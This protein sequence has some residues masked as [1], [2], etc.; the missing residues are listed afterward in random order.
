[1]HIDPWH[2]L[3]HV[4]AARIALGRS[5]GSVPTREQLDFRLAHA[6]ARDAVH[7][8][9]DPDALREKLEAQGTPAMIV[10]SAARDRAE[11]LQRPD[12][13]RIL[14][15]ESR[16]LLVKEAAAQTAPCDLAIIV[17]DGLST[18]AA[19]TQSEPLLAALLPQVRALGWTLAPIVVASHGRVALQDEVGHLFRA[20][21]S[22]MLIGERP[23]LGNADSLGAYFTF[24]PAP[25]KTDA[26]RNCISNLRPGGLP[27]I[28]AAAK[29][30]Y[31]LKQSRWLGFSGVEL[32]DDAPAFTLDQ[33]PKPTIEE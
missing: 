10:H 25:G 13:G 14:A 7:S 18:L 8:F 21:I 19:T 26:E 9:F 31:L 4:T 28:V 3:K 22:L 33:E 20:R 27:P 30:H 2:S 23:G 15:S 5:G 1:M 11:Y 16:E 6:R 29:L 24:G 32:K 12:L 17:S